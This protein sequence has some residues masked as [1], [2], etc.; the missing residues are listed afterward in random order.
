MGSD[1]LVVG[2][3]P[4][5]A[6]A[7]YR[8]ARA[9]ARVTILDPSHPR[10]KPCG[11]GVTGRALGVVRELLPRLAPAVVVTHAVFEHLDGEALDRHQREGQPPDEPAGRRATA[12]VALPADGLSPASALAVFSR[13][14]FDG[15]LL[16]AAL[17]A[18]ARLVPERVVDVAVTPAGVEARTARD[19]HRG[20]WLLG[21]DGATGVVRRRLAF[22]FTRAQL[23]VATGF[24]AHG[25]SSTA[26]AIAVLADPPGY[27]WAFPRSD[28]LAVGIGAPADC[29]VSARRL[30]AV[31]RDWLGATGLARGARLEP[32]GWPIP[33]LAASDLDRERPAGPRWMLLGDAAGLVDPLTREGLYFALRSGEWAASAIAADPASAAR[34]YEA[35]L[36]DEVY[37][38]LAR[39]AR[40]CDGFFDAPF[41]GLMVDAVARS[42]R[43]AA[44]LVDLIA[45][46]QP[47]RGLRRR[48]LKT[49]EWRYAWH[50]ARLRLGRPI[51]R[52]RATA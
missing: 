18:G 29:G 14:D 31:T 24:F 37:P 1:V 33:S 45:G 52:V 25:A 5:G 23:S 50:L 10:E 22:P 7:A 3:G 11:G 51:D 13:R 32:Y 26:I 6:W 34:R 35:R 48:L 19:R 8:L 47:Y 42:S 21:A 43:I 44:V 9:G 12:R 49:R 20:A 36:R 15:A 30:R 46:R 4:A 41:L 40:R 27:L 2:A 17:D 28:H 16:G 39:A 38:E